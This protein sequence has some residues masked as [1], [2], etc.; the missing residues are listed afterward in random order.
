M[1]NCAPK[2]VRRWSRQQSR[3]DYWPS[4]KNA[5]AAMLSTN[6]RRTVHNV[7]LVPRN[8]G[9]AF[10]LLYRKVISPIYGDVCRYYPTCSA[11]GLE[12]VQV[13]GLVRGGW[14]ALRRITRCHPWAKPDFDHVPEPKRPYALRRTKLGFVVSDLQAKG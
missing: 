10:L 1:P 11:Y 4:Q 5:A 13:Y 2:Y 6:V 14:M 12:A 3:L 7:A 9:V 8:L